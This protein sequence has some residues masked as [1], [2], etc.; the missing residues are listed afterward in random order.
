M[1]EDEEMSDGA[2]VQPKDTVIK[3]GEAQIATSDAKAAG[4]AQGNIE[5]HEADTLQL[6]E[7]I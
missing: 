4:I 5:V 1:D 7:V 6:P 3:F 2:L